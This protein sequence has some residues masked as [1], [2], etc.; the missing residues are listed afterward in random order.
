M[1]SSC[2]RFYAIEISVW[3]KRMS[4]NILQR[5]LQIRIENPLRISRRLGGLQFKSGMKCIVRD[6]Y[7]LLAEI[8]EPQ[9]AC[10]TCVLPFRA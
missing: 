10:R 6:A 8:V 5:I 4:S 2:Y 1:F 9:C 7:S 3:Q